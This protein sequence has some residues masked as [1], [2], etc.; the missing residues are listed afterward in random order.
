[1]K[2][3]KCHLKSQCLCCKETVYVSYIRISEEREKPLPR[4][5]QSGILFYMEGAK[6]TL[7]WIKLLLIRSIALSSVLGTM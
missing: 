1:M 3:E 2:V 4:F 6:N 5:N 7:S